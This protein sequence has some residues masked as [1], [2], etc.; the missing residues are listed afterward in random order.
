MSSDKDKRLRSEDFRRQAEKR[1]LQKAEAISSQ[2]GM[3]REHLEHELRVYH[4]E[5]E[6]QNEDL[7]RAQE[8]L[9]KS[10]AKY[11]DLFE[12][13]PVGYFTLGQKNLIV[14][15]N[16]AGAAILGVDRFSLAG[17]RFTNFI[18]RKAAEE[19]LAEYRDKLKEMAA[20]ILSVEDRERKRIAFDS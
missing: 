17:R 12:L 7:R 11:F 15:A 1:I 8:E 20:R 10:R 6:L 19:K 3:D 13:A 4:L 9:E 16:L 14:E 18:A 5:L 2:T